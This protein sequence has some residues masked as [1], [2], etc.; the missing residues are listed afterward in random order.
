MKCLYRPEWSRHCA[1]SSHWV[2]VTI[3]VFPELNLVAGGF[4]ARNLAYYPLPRPGMAGQLLPPHAEQRRSC[5]AGQL[6]NKYYV[7]IGVITGYHRNRV[8]RWHFLG[9]NRPEMFF[10]NCCMSNICHPCTITIDNHLML[11]LLWYKA[12]AH[13]YFPTGSF[14][15]F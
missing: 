2:E 9:K 7:A 1:R 10:L 13:S 14:H 11:S 15:S 5:R 6:T 8:E 12:F 3:P 4:P